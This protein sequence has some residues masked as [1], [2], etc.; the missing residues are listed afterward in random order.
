MYFL[1]MPIRASVLITSIIIILRVI[2][3]LMPAFFALL[4]ASIV[5]HTNE[6]MVTKNLFVIYPQLIML[7]FVIIF[8]FGGNTIMSLMYVFLKTRIQECFDLEILK[9]I[10]VLPY[11]Y[12][13][14]KQVY[15]L[16]HRIEC[17]YDVYI[18]NG[19]KVYLRVVGNLLELTSITYIIF[20]TSSWW[21]AL[22]LF[23][24][25]I[26]L[27][28]VSVSGGRENYNA[29]VEASVEEQKVNYL[30]NLLL[31]KEAALERR[32]FAFSNWLQSKWKDQYTKAQQIIISTQ[33]K[34]IVR[35]KAS[36]ILTVLVSVIVCVMF[37]PALL[38][39]KMSLGVFYGLVTAVFNFVILVSWEVAD[40]F[41]QLVQCQA[42]SADLRRFFDLEE[43][44]SG[45]DVMDTV[46]EEVTI[47]FENVSF[48]YPDCT[49]YVL[50]N[51]NIELHSGKHYAIVGTNGSGKST[52][53][54]L[55]IGLYTN[56]DGKIKINGKDIRELPTENLRKY[57]SVA[58]QDFVKYNIPLREYFELGDTV[59]E[60]ELWKFLHAFEMD[61]IIKTWPKGLNTAI[62][63][64]QSDG[65]EISQGQWQRVM[66]A[67][68][69]LH[70]APV[71]IF[72]EPT[73]AIDPIGERKLYDQIADMTAGELTIFITHRLGAAKMADEILVLSD[74]IIA[75]VG[76]HDELI[77]YG[78]LYA[79]MYD[80][81]KGWYVNAEGQ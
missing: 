8:Q 46:L 50:K 13:E 44:T 42:Y 79:Q 55:L 80:T 66:L 81:Q 19:F 63:R 71:R 52:I 54:K 60:S 47:S 3:G 67:K 26:P 57:Y 31:G 18:T 78:G 30:N 22:V 10:S 23:L 34:S 51:I 64:L 62:G 49:D 24:F 76:T 27:I 39:C 2:Q 16:I 20:T 21:S 4:I 74:G 32:L 68:T 33:I 58:F 48:C 43:I 35:M 41:N 29:N 70:K 25:S 73:S 12:I 17:K 28:V 45:S 59:N 40:T 11:H 5:D 15:E 37:I 69:L 36:S 65:H 56:Y 14:N 61:Q 9:K 75:E 1:S 77:I 7:L 53:I 72:D 38:E 6:V